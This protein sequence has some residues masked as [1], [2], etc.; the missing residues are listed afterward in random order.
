MIIS[1]YAKKL[2]AIK[3]LWS[4]DQHLVDSIYGLGSQ[5]GVSQFSFI[6]KQNI[7]FKTIMGGPPKKLLLI[8]S[9]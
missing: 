5:H 6:N 1:A 8:P 2:A 3:C 7:E 9:L 4:V